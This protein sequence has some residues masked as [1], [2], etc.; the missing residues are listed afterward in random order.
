MTR[1]TAAFAA[2]IALVGVLAGIVGTAP[3]VGSTVLEQR[4]STT[5]TPMYLSY[6]RIGWIEPSYSGRWNIYVGYQRVGYLRQSYSNR[7]N[8]YVGYQLVGY[9]RP[10]YSNRW[11]VYVDYLSVGYVRQSYGSSWNAYWDFQPIGYATGFGGHL[12]AGVLIALYEL[13]Y[14]G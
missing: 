1:R 3:T 9:V 12:A 8:I 13:G 5:R 7:W 2:S 11:N 10:S 14:V 6:S 4:V